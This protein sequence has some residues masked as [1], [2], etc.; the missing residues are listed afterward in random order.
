M[1]III[2]V[3]AL[4]RKKVEARTEARRN[5]KEDRSGEVRK[6]D[7]RKRLEEIEEEIESRIEERNEARKERLQRRLARNQRKLPD[8]YDILDVTSSRNRRKSSEFKGPSEF[9]SYPLVNRKPQASRDLSQP[10]FTRSQSPRKSSWDL[11]E[12]AQIYSNDPLDNSK[13]I[14]LPNLRKLEGDLPEPLSDSFDILKSKFPTKG[15][16]EE[17]LQEVADSLS[18]VGPISEMTVPNLEEAANSTIK[19]LVLLGLPTY[20]Q[21]LMKTNEQ[22][23]QVLDSCMHSLLH[24]VNSNN[25]LQGFQIEELD[26]GTNQKELVLRNLKSGSISPIRDLDSKKIAYSIVGKVNT[27][28]D[29]ISEMESINDLV[30]W[31]ESAEHLQKTMKDVGT[32]FRSVAESLGLKIDVGEIEDFALKLH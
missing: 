26:T 15:E 28:L 3:L 20:N 21:A 18:V 10:L 12:E 30:K 22:D 9:S 19:L 17:A 14:N 25:I 6:E 31:I 29:E 5:R 2:S 16:I 24:L 4:E 8:I 32:S 13:L 1:S 7:L 23:V 11:K 27:M